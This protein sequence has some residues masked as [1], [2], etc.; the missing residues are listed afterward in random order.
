[1]LAFH[2]NKSSM[3]RTI[4]EFILR[5]SNRDHGCQIVDIYDFLRL[6]GPDNTDPHSFHID[7]FT[8][9][10]YL[11]SYLNKAYV[12]VTT[13]HKMK[14]SVKESLMKICELHTEK[15]NKHGE[16]KHLELAQNIRD[17]KLSLDREFS[18]EYL[19]LGNASI[20]ATDDY[21]TLTHAIY[22]AGKSGI[23]SQTLASLLKMPITNILR[24]IE[25]TL[26][27]QGIIIT[28]QEFCDFRVFVHTRWFYSANSRSLAS[29]FIDTYQCTIR[30]TIVDDEPAIPQKPYSMY[31]EYEKLDV[32]CSDGA[33]VWNMNYYRTT[34]AYY[35]SLYHHLRLYAT[36]PN[37]AVAAKSQRTFTGIL[38]K[39]L[40]AESSVTDRLNVFGGKVIAA[41]DAGLAHISYIPKQRDG[42]YYQRVN[43]DSSLTRPKNHI[44]VI[45]VDIDGLPANNYAHII[46]T[47]SIEEAKNRFGRKISRDMAKMPEWLHR[48]AFKV[49]PP[50]QLSQRES[51]MKS[52]DLATSTLFLRRKMTRH[53]VIKS[54][55]VQMDQLIN[56]SEENSEI[57]QASIRNG[58]QKNYFERAEFLHRHMSFLML[59]L[60][61]SDNHLEGMYT[62]LPNDQDVY[63]HFKKTHDLRKNMADHIHQAISLQTIFE[64]MP[65]WL[66]CTLFQGMWDFRKSSEDT[67]K[68]DV[69]SIQDDADRWTLPTDMRDVLLC[70]VPSLAGRTTPRASVYAQFL[71]LIYQLD[72]FRLIDMRHC[73]RTFPT[74]ET[75]VVYRYPFVFNRPDSNVTEK[76]VISKALD[77]LWQNVRSELGKMRSLQNSFGVSKT[78]GGSNLRKGVVS[79]SHN[80]KI[81]AIIDSHLNGQERNLALPW[82]FNDEFVS[83]VKLDPRCTPEFRALL[84]ER[85]PVIESFMKSLGAS[86][87]FS[88][89]VE[90]FQYQTTSEHGGSNGPKVSGPSVIISSQRTYIQK[91]FPEPFLLFI[92]F[93]ASSRKGARDQEFLTEIVQL[94]YD[95]LTK[96]FRSLLYTRKQVMNTMYLQSVYHA[97]TVFC[98]EKCE[99]TTEKYRAIMDALV[100]AIIELFYG[101]AIPCG[102][103]SDGNTLADM[104]HL[105]SICEHIEPG[106]FTEFISS[107][108]HTFDSQTNG[109]ANPELNGFVDWTGIPPTWAHWARPRK[110]ELAALRNLRWYSETY[111]TDEKSGTEQD[112]YDNAQKVIPA[113]VDSFAKALLAE[114]TAGNAD[115][116]DSDTQ[117]ALQIMRWT[118]DSF[119][120]VNDLSII[121]HASDS[122]H[123]TKSTYLR[124]A[125]NCGYDS[126]LSS[127]SLTPKLEQIEAHIFPKVVLSSKESSIPYASQLQR[128]NVDREHQKI[129]WDEVAQ[130]PEAPL[131]KRSAPPKFPSAQTNW[132]KPRIEI[133]PKLQ[134]AKTNIV[135]YL[136]LNPGSEEMTIYDNTTVSTLISV[137]EYSALLEEMV[138]EKILEVECYRA[139]CSRARNSIIGPL[140]MRAYSIIV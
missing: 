100:Y 5:T 87:R 75:T 126:I 70:E 77:K 22:C 8:W 23:K 134:Q 63:E 56:F 124:M 114:K 72:Q 17:F 86:T 44:D 85:L 18:K 123:P 138:R 99:N 109:T 112:P 57:L 94:P 52:G 139:R 66:F 130:L 105:S 58:Y 91:Q 24:L 111:I 1:M 45:N 11:R 115:L 41:K 12:E 46:G 137:Q 116:E 27:P 14:G 50:T 78:F 16:T 103:E 88:D 125:I 36:F 64:R 2:T 20:P 120:G 35:S 29:R 28:L 51:E 79:K 74:E 59:E 82:W 48:K 37:I 47:L 113:A 89:I 3:F 39:A 49:L 61:A 76:D 136:M 71:I 15:E 40:Y 13:T 104:K 95:R 101:S 135:A 127:K 110:Y 128:A 33:R 26:G 98:E 81:Q 119:H 92:A 43:S 102:D 97:A 129:L 106:V 80:T 118:V 30:N 42:M 4:D 108:Q 83:S 10:F 73:L 140:W 69:N 133:E 96:Q 38:K 21:L 19:Y 7:E 117:Q 107:R 131:E 34:N 65:L 93:V 67:G 62:Q 132:S 32:R 60:Y 121:P 84:R 68:S 122:V 54:T 53:K 90:H 25:S 9:P 31:N 6:K 55:F